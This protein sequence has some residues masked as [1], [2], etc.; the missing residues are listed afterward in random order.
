MKQDERLK[1]A[2]KKIEN[3]EDELSVAETELYELQIKIIADFFNIPTDNLEFNTEIGSWDCKD[4][5]IGVCFYNP[6]TDPALDDCLICSDPDE[7][8]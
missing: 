7:R 8:K 5:P 6:R 4:S 3:L 1:E 2:A